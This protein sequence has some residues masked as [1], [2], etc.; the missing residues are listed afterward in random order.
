MPASQTPSGPS[1]YG[2]DSEVVPMRPVHLA[3]V[4]SEWSY[5]MVM[6]MLLTRRGYTVSPGAL[7]EARQIVERERPDVLLLDAGDLQ[8]Q[9]ERSVM[10]ARS[11]QEWTSV[12]IVAGRATR[13]RDMPVFARWGPLP[14]LLTALRRAERRRLTHR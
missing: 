7:G 1:G 10:L 14:E 12:V 6:S 8:D 2:D 4:T 13:V 5:R 11:L 9:L 3:L